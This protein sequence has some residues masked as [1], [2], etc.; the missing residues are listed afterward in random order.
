MA[1]SGFGGRQDDGAWL[2]GLCC[3]SVKGGGDGLRC[4]AV[5]QALGLKGILNA[6]LYKK[7][8]NNA[9]I[10]ALCFTALAPA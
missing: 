4:G 3:V 7:I 6:S 1:R 2:V 9:I 8:L 10:P 5:F